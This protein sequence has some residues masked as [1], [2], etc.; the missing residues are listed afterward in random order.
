MAED[1]MV[2]QGE[3]LSSIAYEHGFF[4]RTLWNHPS[5]AELKT[6]RKNPN[7]LLK[8]DT[9]HIPDLTLKQES[10]ATEQL[11]KFKLKGVP[12][13]LRI[14]LLD[15]SKKPRANLDYIIVIDGDSRR[16]KTDSKGLLVESIPPNAQQGKLIL[17]QKR[18]ETIALNLG[19]LDPITEL[20]GVKARMVNLGLY[21]GGIDA[22]LDAATKKALSDFQVQQGLPVTGAPDDATRQ[23]L[24][25]L[26]GH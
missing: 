16:G 8:G 17:G 26:H 13:K 6:Q 15:A 2:E 18:A 21:R 11:H 10:G 22:N 1:Y 4:W 3:C 9:V 5:N 19:R 23:K 20:S 24:L 7:V 25:Q 12:E 14:T